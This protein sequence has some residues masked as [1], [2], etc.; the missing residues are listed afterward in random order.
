MDLDAYLSLP[1]SLNASALRIRMV[2]LGAD[3]KSDAQIRQWR[4][5]YANR[6]PS[7]ENCVFIEQ[8][9]EGL[10][11]RWDLRPEDWRRNWPELIGADGAPA[12]PEQEPSHG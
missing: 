10:V 6:L 12:T 1:N 5:R 11:R 3:V 8:A 9:T 7:P 2:E 4:Y